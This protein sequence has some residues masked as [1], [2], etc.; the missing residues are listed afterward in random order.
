MVEGAKVH[1][2][3]DVDID[4][5][6]HEGYYVERWLAEHVIGKIPGAEISHEEES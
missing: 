5:T 4:A 1:L 6:K 2:T 3:V